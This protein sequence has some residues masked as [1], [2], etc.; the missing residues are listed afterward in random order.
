MKFLRK[1]L[2]K[3]QDKVEMHSSSLKGILP[4][5]DFEKLGLINHNRLC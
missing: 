4:T 5:E 1:E 2:V 3:V